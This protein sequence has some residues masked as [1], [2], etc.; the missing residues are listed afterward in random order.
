MKRREALAG[1][2]ALGVLGAGGAAA[3]RGVGPFASDD[4]DRIEPVE[5]ERLDAPG[6]SPGTATVPE[7]GNVTYISLFATWCTICQRKMEPLG[8]AAANVDDGVQFISVTNEPVGR[9]VSRADVVD[10]WVEYDGTWPV[11][12]DD[13]LELTRRLPDAA[14]VPY[15]VVLDAENQVTWSE[16]GYHEA[17][18]IVSHIDEA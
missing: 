13:N 1:L 10:W 8:T 2:G 17:D 11:A 6:S 14:G 3:F 7:A 4:D 12:L 15:S 16:P 18:T 5:L 9:T